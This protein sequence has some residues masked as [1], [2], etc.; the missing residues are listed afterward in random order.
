VTTGWP[1]RP[2]C[3]R[4][5][6][7]KALAACRV[8]MRA[9]DPSHP[10][11]RFSALQGALQGEEVTRPAL[12][13]GSAPHSALLTLQVGHRSNGQH[14]GVGRQDH[15]WPIRSPITVGLGCRVCREEADKDGQEGLAR[16]PPP[17]RMAGEGQPTA[18]HTISTTLTWVTP[19]PT[20][21]GGATWL[22]K[23]AMSGRTMPAH[24]GNR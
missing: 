7:T 2:L 14:Q 24:T 20:L 13:Q 16:A 5:T 18:L 21:R 22:L 10:L 8:H 9:G 4:L 3:M 11:L 15:R 1:H 6:P 19:S 12:F 17:T 23:W